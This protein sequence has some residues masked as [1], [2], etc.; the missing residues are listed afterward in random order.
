MAEAALFTT[1]AGALMA[2]GGMTLATYLCRIGGVWMMDHVP[3]TPR[4]RRAL[5]ALPG[6][7]IISTVL[8]LGVKA[9]P[10]AMA[11]LGVAMLVMIRTRRDIFALVAGLATVSL[12]RA[13]GL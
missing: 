1:N 4:V 5:A 7:I 12:L 8:P 9:G 3:L 13:A 11:A 6:S 2:L 10:A